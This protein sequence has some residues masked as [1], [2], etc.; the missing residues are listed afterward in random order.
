MPSSKTL[1]AVGLL[2]VTAPFVANAGERVD[3]SF[4]EGE[5]ATPAARQLLL[6]RIER[7]S[8]QSCG[9]ASALVTEVATKR[10]ADDLTDQFV[11]AIANEALSSL[12][13][14][15]ARAAYR[16]ARR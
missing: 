5:L 12:A 11:R 9:S 14:S 1:L 8:L 6:E 10:C 7:A 2:A 4:R 13:E 15:K 16:T 3:F